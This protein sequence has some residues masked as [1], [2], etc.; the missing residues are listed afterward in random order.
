MS[1]YSDIVELLEK[2]RHPVSNATIRTHLYSCRPYADE[3]HPNLVY[4][5]ISQLRKKGYRI[6]NV[7][8]QGWQLD[9]MG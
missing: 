3:P 7:Y 9:A 5:L 4:V 2:R 1:H 6:K 8:G